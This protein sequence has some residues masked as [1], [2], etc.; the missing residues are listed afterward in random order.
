MMDIVSFRHLLSFIDIVINHHLTT[1]PVERWKSKT[2][3]FHLPLEETTITLEDVA[4]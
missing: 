2:H 4:L 3:T 1:I